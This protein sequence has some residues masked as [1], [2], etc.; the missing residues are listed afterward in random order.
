MK[1]TANHPTPGPVT[2]ERSSAAESVGVAPTR[3]VRNAADVRIVLR[4]PDL[5]A[6]LDLAPE[7]KPQEE[8]QITTYV[9][10]AVLV[11]VLT[12]LAVDHWKAGHDQYDGPRTAKT[13]APLWQGPAETSPSGS[14]KLT[15]SA[16]DAKAASDLPSADSQ[17]KEA[18][19]APTAKLPAQDRQAANT[20]APAQ[21]STADGGAARTERVASKPGPTASGP[22][23]APVAK[24]EGV[25]EKPTPE[26]TYD[27]AQ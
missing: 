6:P 17:T 26:P 11:A 4:L 13:S 20:G 10:A 2:E 1:S 8:S 25:I 3:A 16:T 23:Q 24:L 15:R 7:P 22:S 18:A 5:N 27:S 12:F 19:P 14:Q 21:P 9:L